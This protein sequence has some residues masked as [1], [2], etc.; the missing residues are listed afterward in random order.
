MI[1]AVVLVRVKSWH[2]VRDAV[3]DQSGVLF[4]AAESHLGDGQRLAVEIR[5]MVRFLSVGTLQCGMKRR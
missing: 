4:R 2:A 5:W 1:A 3:G